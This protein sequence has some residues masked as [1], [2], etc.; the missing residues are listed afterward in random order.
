MDRD[1][2]VACAS[3]ETDAGG[4]DWL[5]QLAR[6]CHTWPS[7]LFPCRIDSGKHG[8]QSACHCTGHI[9]ALM[10]T[11][12]SVSPAA[13]AEVASAAAAAASAH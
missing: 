10:K 12:S 7:L 6:A 8:R 3:V 13:A 1:G 9:T 2:E 4:R 5:R 11:A